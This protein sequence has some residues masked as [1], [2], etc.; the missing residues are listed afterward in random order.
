M[1]TV[2]KVSIRKISKHVS[3]NKDTEI[4]VNDGQGLSITPMV[5]RVQ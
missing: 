1:F 4:D 5:E 3:E 2:D